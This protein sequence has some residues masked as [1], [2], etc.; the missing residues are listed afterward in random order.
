MISLPPLLV[1]QFESCSRLEQWWV[2]S[3]FLL[4]TLANHDI[5]LLGKEATVNLLK[6]LL[7]MTENSLRME[8]FFYYLTQ[9]HAHAQNLNKSGMEA[10]FYY[11]HLQSI[12]VD[13]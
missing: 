8:A 6:R 2:G 7:T 13:Y 11:E 4:Q 1:L 3:Y 5:P 12:T 9:V 10:M